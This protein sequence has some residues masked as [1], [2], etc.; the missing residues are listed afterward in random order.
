[1]KILSRIIVTLT[2]LGIIIWQLG[3][4][5]EV[6]EIM[7]GLDPRYA[8][9]AFFVSTVDRLLMTFKWT[10]LLRIKGIYLPLFQGMKIY[11]AS[12]IWGIFMPSTVGADAIRVFSTSRKG[13][14]VKE[15][16]VSIVIERMIGFLSA[17]LL[18]IIGLILISRLTNIGPR[19][20][21]IFWLTGVVIALG[22]IGFI[23][24][25]SQLSFDIIHNRLLLKF[26]NTRVM[27]RVRE[28][29]VSYQDYKGNKSKLFEFFGMTFGE[30]LMPILFNWL[31]AKGLG[32]EVGLLFMA[33]ALPLSIL[34][35]RLPIS[36]DGLGVFDG[37]FILFMSLAGFSAAQ[38]VSIAFAGRIIQTLSWLP[39]WMAHVIGN[40]SIFPPRTDNQCVAKEV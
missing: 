11:C 22:I 6:S 29:H 38:A 24:S 25:L 18:G 12:M 3:G 8:I 7:T 2:L 14:D 17:L 30:Q 16:L 15:I 36:I 9:L 39:W 37:A 40:K 1:M 31:L 5:D 20:A 21:P 10:W 28:F 35:A 13:H 19:F 4:F 32:I 34:I 23:F 33:G 26:K 27:Q